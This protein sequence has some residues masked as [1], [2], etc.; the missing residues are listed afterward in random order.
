VRALEAIE[1]RNRGEAIEI[2]RVIE[3]KHNVAF[4]STLS[5]ALEGWKKATQRSLA[6]PLGVC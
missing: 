6:S 2:P 3:P 4:G 1:K 5:A